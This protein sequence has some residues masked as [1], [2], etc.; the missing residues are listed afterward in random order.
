MRQERF[1]GSEK[2]H[3]EKEYQA[4]GLKSEKFESEKSQVWDGAGIFHGDIDDTGGDYVP[5]FWFCGRTGRTF[6]DHSHHPDR[7]CGNDSD[8]YG[9]RGDCD[10]PEGG[11]R[12]RVLHCESVLWSGNRCHYWDSPVSESGD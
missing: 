4:W 8:G 12:W 9:H 6:G 3:N 1:V 2:A 7:S 10:Q 5:P 11:G